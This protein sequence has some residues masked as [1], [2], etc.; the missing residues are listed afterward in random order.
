MKF[1]RAIEVNYKF[2]LVSTNLNIEKGNQFYMGT[3][4]AYS[5]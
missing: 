1:N 4:R 3:L 2:E 5:V